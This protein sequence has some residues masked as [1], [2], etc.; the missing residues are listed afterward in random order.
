MLAAVAGPALALGCLPEGGPGLGEPLITQRGLYGLVFAPARDDGPAGV[1]YG[2]RASVPRPPPAAGEQTSAGWPEDLF[3]LGEGAAPRLLLEDYAGPSRWDA[4]GRLY[5]QRD[6]SF[7]FD[8]ARESG[9]ATF[10]LWRFELPGAAGLLLGRMAGIELSPAG[11]RVVYGSAAGQWVLRTLDDR[12]FPLPAL[13]QHQF[14][15][16][17]LYFVSE[18]AILRVRDPEAPPA[19]VLP[20]RAASFQVRGQADGHLVLQIADAPEGWRIALVAAAGPE[21][22]SQVLATTRPLAGPALAPDGR[23]VAWIERAGEPPSDRGRLRIRELDSGAE[24]AVEIG[25]PPPPGPS[26]GPDLPLTPVPARQVEVDLEFRPGSDQLWA[27]F[28]REVRV[29]DAAGQARLVRRRGRSRTGYTLPRFVDAERFQGGSSGVPSGA[30]D[31]QRSSRFSSDGRFWTLIDDEENGH[32]GPADDPAAPPIVRLF[33][34]GGFEPGVLEVGPGRQVAFWSSADADRNELQLADLGARTIR[35]LARNVS[36][37]Q[38]GGARVLLLGRASSGSGE[39]PGDLSLVE[40]TTGAVTHLA[41]NVTDFA[42]EAACPLCDPTDPG[43]RLVYV[44]NARFPWRYDGLWRG[45]L[46]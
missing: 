43:A 29:F 41:S 17:D 5:V 4:A 13:G 11:R 25:L 46:P 37:L 19:L 9:V 2:R 27:F 30:R 36:R 44:V 40:L 23:R 22:T 42:L 14:V 31:P 15:G 6:F 12:E 21:P 24:R 8:P 39:G 35:R 28:E 18:G 33:G 20:G 16:E 10:E 45:T 34:K 32:L 7:R 3:Y 26:A 38:F 1:L